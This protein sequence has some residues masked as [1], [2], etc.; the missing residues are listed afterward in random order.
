M[1]SSRSILRRLR[2]PRRLVIFL[3]VLL[4]LFLAVVILGETTGRR[5][6]WGY[7]WGGPSFDAGETQQVLLSEDFSTPSN[8]WAMGETEEASF[9]WDGGAY[10]ISAKAP[11][12]VQLQMVPLEPGSDAIEIGVEAVQ[13]VGNNDD[14]IGV[15]CGGPGAQGA[16][17]GYLVALNARSGVMAVVPYRASED[18]IELGGPN[19]SSRPRRQRCGDSG[20]RTRFESTASDQ[21]STAAPQS[22]CM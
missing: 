6:G 17:Q 20:G 18:G 5:S 15:L 21:I 4:A 1:A 13:R 14:A 22:S 10:R 3:G 16:G 8:A 19:Q 7:V 11:G 2:P 9:G 12:R